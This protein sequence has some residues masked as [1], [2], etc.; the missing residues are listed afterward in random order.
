[1]IYAAL[2]ALLLFSIYVGCWL[3]F[4]LLAHIFISLSFTLTYFLSW[5]DKMRKAICPNGFLSA[6]LYK[7]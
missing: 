3:T 7:D 4:Y 6:L 5:D 1:M 2:F